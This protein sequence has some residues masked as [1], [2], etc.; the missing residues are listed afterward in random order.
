MPV[1]VT[2]VA[3]DANGRNA[4][5]A[6]TDQTLRV[7]DLETGV[8]LATFICDGQAYSCA[9]ISHD[10]VIAGDALGRVHFLELE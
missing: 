2:A 9:F 1:S 6:S 4:V 5:S 3:V 7:W 8:L 10:K